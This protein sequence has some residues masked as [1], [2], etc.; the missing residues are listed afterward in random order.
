MY[1]MFSKSFKSSK[2]LRHQQSTIKQKQS[3]QKKKKQKQ[4]HNECEK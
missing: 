1:I 3:T 4:I 2:M